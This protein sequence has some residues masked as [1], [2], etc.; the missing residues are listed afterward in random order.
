MVEI[1]MPMMAIRCLLQCAHSASE[2]AQ[3]EDTAYDCFEQA[4]TLFEEEIGQSSEKSSALQAIIGTL[5]RCHVFGEESRSSLN[6]AV[7]GYCSMMLTKE[8]H[9]RSLC[10]YSRLFWQEGGAPGGGARDGEGVIKAL[11]RC[12]KLASR[13]QRKANILKRLGKN[14]ETVMHTPLNTLY[15]AVGWTV[16]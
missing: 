6:Q 8:E 14:V 9:C 12:I 13:A 1:P 7:L 15:P 2:E 3:L 11:Q 4:C 10:L 5:Y 16:R